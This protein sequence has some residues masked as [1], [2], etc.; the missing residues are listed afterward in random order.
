MTTLEKNILDTFKA[1]LLK[2][3]LLYKMILFGSRARGDA[4][5]Y[6]DMDVLVV[7]DKVSGGQD[8]EYVSECAWEAGFEHGIVVVPVV[9]TREEW[10][11]SPER[12]SLLAQAV[13]DEGVLI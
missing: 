4:A 9:F 5:Q 7:L 2:R 6:S 13:K 8:Y 11:D 3:L 1:L 12:Y 10:E